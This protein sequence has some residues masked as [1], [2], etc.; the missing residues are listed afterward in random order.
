LENKSSIIQRHLYSDFIHRKADLKKTWYTEVPLPYEKL[1]PHLRNTL[2]TITGEIS[3]CKSF[4]PFPF[5]V[6][7]L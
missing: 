5:P 1:L 2:E 3:G 7:D 6:P 4:K